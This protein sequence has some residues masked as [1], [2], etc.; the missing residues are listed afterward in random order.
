[1]T[2]VQYLAGA[3]MGFFLFATVSR[4][5]LGHTQPSIQ[6]ILGT[7]TPRVKQLGHKADYSPPSSAEV[8]NAWSYASTPPYI[9]M[10]C[11]LVKYRD[12][13]TSLQDDFYSLYQYTE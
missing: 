1:M 6:W 4:L 5:A 12:N 7:L 11:C 9:F 13:F 2:R 10:A 3:I 8:K